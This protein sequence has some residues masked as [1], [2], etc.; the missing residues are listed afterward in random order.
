MGILSSGQLHPAAPSR[1]F[2][3]FFQALVMAYRLR[4]FVPS[5]SWP[6]IDVLLPRKSNAHPA[7]PR[8][9]G[10]VLM[11]TCHRTTH[12]EGCA[13]S[14]HAAAVSRRRL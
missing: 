11:D 5:S 14:I 7:L 6:G 12:H 4:S 3:R 1:R 10:H 2:A 9:W 13:K 8:D